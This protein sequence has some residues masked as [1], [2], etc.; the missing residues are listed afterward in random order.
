MKKIYLLFY[1]D[2]LKLK[3]KE[4]YKRKE[5]REEFDI[6]FQLSRIAFNANY[7]KAAVIV[8][9]SWNELAGNSIICILSKNNSGNWYIIESKVLEIS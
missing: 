1:A 4:S 7:T 9:I 5:Y 8:S 3:A 2:T 6:L